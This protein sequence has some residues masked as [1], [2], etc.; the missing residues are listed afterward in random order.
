MRYINLRLLTYLLTTVYTGNYSAT[1]NNISWYTGRWWVGCYIWYSKEG[2]RRGRSPP[3][4]LLAVPN[5]TALSPPINGQCANHCIAVYNASLLCGFNVPT[6][7]LN[8]YLKTVFYN[9][10]WNH[11]RTFRTDINTNNTIDSMLLLFTLRTA[12]TDPAWLAWNTFHFET[13]QMKPLVLT[14]W[15][16]TPNH[17]TTNVF[18]A[19][20]VIIWHIACGNSWSGDR[21][22][23]GHRRWTNAPCQ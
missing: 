19:N 8:L 22:H 15:I 21:L 10:R 6:K 9:I 16:V 12:T 14:V 7:R 11:S 5:V 20:T 2:T 3:R 13:L 17:S 18:L 1:A 23:A 4:P